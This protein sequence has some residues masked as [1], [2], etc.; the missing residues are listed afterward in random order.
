MKFDFLERRK[1]IYLLFHLL[2][3]LLLVSLIK[4]VTI[5]EQMKNQNTSKEY[6]KLGS[7]NKEYETNKLKARFSHSLNNK[8][9][10]ANKLGSESQVSTKNNLRFNNNSKNKQFPTEIGLNG[11]FPEVPGD[12]CPCASQMPPC[13]TPEFDSFYC[14]CIA[15]PDCGVCSGENLNIFSSY[16]DS[17]LKLAMKDAFNQ[18][19]LAQKA[20]L[21]VELFQKAQDYAKEVGIQEMKAKQYARVLNEATKKAQIARAM[22][23][24]SASQVRLLADKTLKAISP[25]RAVVS[26]M[27]PMGHTDHVIHEHGYFPDQVHAPVPGSH[28]VNNYNADTSH[29]LNNA[30]SDAFAMRRS[31]QSLENMNNPTMA[32]YS[33]YGGEY[34]KSGYFKDT[35]YNPGSGR[36]PNYSNYDSNGRE[37]A[38]GSK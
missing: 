9:Q 15:K 5:K 35:S 26:P 8:S 1:H 24:Q 23:F 32:S 38:Y 37:I 19:D 30:F 22:M 4:S 25:M 27:H 7:T 3:F 29:V 11:S 20:K 6:D 12:P 34:S 13:C 10:I 28:M 14:P 18:Q 36:L 17:M 33:N 2:S 16:H 31:L 21:Q